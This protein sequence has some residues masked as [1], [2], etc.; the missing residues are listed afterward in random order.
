[1]QN[2]NQHSGIILCMH[3]RENLDPTYHNIVTNYE[4]APGCNPI[5]SEPSL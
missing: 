1:V 3:V 4:Y 5:H 2:K